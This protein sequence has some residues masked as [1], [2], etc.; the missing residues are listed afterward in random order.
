MVE[1]KEPT[2]PE[3]AVERCALEFEQLI[4]DHLKDD[5]GVHIETAITAAG[6]VAGYLLLRETGIDLTAL[7]PGSVV[8][9]DQVNETGPRMVG[10]MA[11]V[12]VREG[13]DP[14]GGWTEKI[15]QAHQPL[16]PAIDL[17]RDLH[18]GLARLADRYG[19]AVELRPR[20]AAAAAIKLVRMG[21]QALDTGLG[22]AIALWAMLSAAKTVPHHSG[23]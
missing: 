7:K 5:R 22:K 12:C 21:S 13:V 9:V 6:S 20:I 10:F 14:A 3:A 8:L 17:A 18:P 1:E 11:E 19:V 15:S 2:T 23:A 4:V 16:F